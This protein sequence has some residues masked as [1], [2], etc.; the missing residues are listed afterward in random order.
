MLGARRHRGSRADAS[1]AVI[2]AN[3]R[4]RYPDLRTLLVAGASRRDD[5]TATALALS[6]AIVRFDNATV[7]VMVLDSAM[8][9]RREPE[10]A[11]PS[12]TVIGA[13]SPDQVRIALSNQRDTVDVSIVVAPAPQTAV[14]CIAVA[15]AADAAILVATAGRTPSAEATLAAE[16][17]RQTGLPPAAAVLLGAPARRSPQPAPARPRPSAA[18]GQAIA[19]LRRA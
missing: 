6:D 2:W 5:P 17:L 15:G 19:E 12:V 18:Q 8:Q 4:K 10:S 13:L 3:L 16:L 14:D 1:Y 7:L 11:S 9:D